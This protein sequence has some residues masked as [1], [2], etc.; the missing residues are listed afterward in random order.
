MLT[1]PYL[2]LALMCHGTSGILDWGPP[3][4]RRSRKLSEM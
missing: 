4:D 2:D 3:S 1:F